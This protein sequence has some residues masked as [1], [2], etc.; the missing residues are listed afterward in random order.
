LVTKTYSQFLAQLL[1][2]YMMT[3]LGLFG[4]FYISKYSKPA[5]RSMKLKMAGN[6][7]KVNDLDGEVSPDAGKIKSG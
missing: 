7:A 5:K 1:V 3:L 2:V 4:N 6:A